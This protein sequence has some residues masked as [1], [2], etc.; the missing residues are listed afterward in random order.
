[1]ARF[2]E[3]ATAA[4]G[5]SVA[6]TKL[7]AFAISAFIA[8]VSGGL[9]AGQVGFLSAQSFSVSQS[10]LLYVLAV[11]LGTQYVDGAVAG[12]VVVTALLT[13]L[14]VNQNWAGVIFGAGALQ[15]LTTGSSLSEDLRL[16][17]SVRRARRRIAGPP[18]AV[19]EPVPE[20]APAA[21]VA[22]APVL[23]VRGLSVRYGAVVALDDVNLTVPS[24]VVKGLIGPNGAGKSTLAD[25][26]A[27][28][29]GHAEGS[30]GL[31]GISLA[32]R[33]VRARARA[34]LRHTFQHDRVPSSLTVGEYI[35]FASG[36]RIDRAGM[37]EVLAYLDCPPPD[38][39]IRTVDTGT[40]RLL[41][42]AGILL[43]KPRLVILDE[44][45]AG[46]GRAGSKILASRLAGIPA[47][48]GASL[49]LIE[50]DLDLIRA[51]CSTV[52]VLD[53]GKVIAEGAP[54][55]VLSRPEVT[56]AYL[57][58]VGVTP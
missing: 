33:S 38:Q 13:R 22:D 3:R 46:P 40:R 5:Y 7:T 28:F 34:G 1:V 25:A 57:G 29:I 53:F 23:E 39:P 55:E 49:L 48:F 16:R 41:E 44:S 27:G 31:G 37:R 26:V 18:A 21:P 32:G 10:L 43:A 35:R 54:A 42:I 9:L 19:V 12:G 8:G 52:V 45:A 51:C 17:A 2:S 30:V 4:V 47:A 56:A 24:G 6:R 11:M 50:H 58:D 15:A 20:A 36:R 14:N